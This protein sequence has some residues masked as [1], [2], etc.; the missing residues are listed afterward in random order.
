MKK[1]SKKIVVIMC[2]C[3]FMFSVCFLFLSN[4]NLS[5][6]VNVVNALTDSSFKQT[7]SV[8][9]IYGNRLDSKK[10]YSSLDYIIFSDIS[11]NST[12]AK[13]GINLKTEFVLLDDEKVS[14]SLL[15]AGVVED[16]T[17]MNGFGYLDF[18]VNEYDS[19]KV[20]IKCLKPFSCV[21]V[22]SAKFENEVKTFEITF[23]ETIIN[24]DFH[25]VDLNTSEFK[26]YNAFNSSALDVGELLLSQNTIFKVANFEYSR[27][28]YFVD[29]GFDFS[30]RININDDALVYLVKFMSDNY[31]LSL[32]CLNGNYTNLIDCL[33]VQNRDNSYSDITEYPGLISEI[34]NYDGQVCTI[35]FLLETQT[36]CYVNNFDV[37]FN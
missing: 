16:S 23:A 13:D 24:C 15:R 9:D 29:N 33:K 5:Q 2:V 18:T 34:K 36:Q 12:H 3:T 26:I 6:D 37:L 17:V 7:K 14:W 31:D 10:E 27:F 20:N 35:D 19:N 8:S 32:V 1:L 30:A 11:K 21:F 25:V 22:L 28:G 4:V